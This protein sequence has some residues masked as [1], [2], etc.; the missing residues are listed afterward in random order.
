MSP[1][2]RQPQLGATARA[3]VAS[4]A[5]SRCKPSP[6]T[7]A[8][9]HP[10]SATSCGAISEIDGRASE[11]SSATTPGIARRAAPVAAALIPCGVRS[12]AMRRHMRASSTHASRAARWSSAS[13]RSSPVSCENVGVSSL[14]AP[15]SGEG[16]SFD[17]AQSAVATPC[18]L[19]SG[20]ACAASSRSRTAAASGARSVLKLASAHSAIESSRP[21]KLRSLHKTRTRASTA[22]ND[23][24]SGAQP[25]FPKPCNHCAASTALK[26]LVASVPARRSIACIAASGG[27]PLRSPAAE[28]APAAHAHCAR[29]LASTLSAHSPTRERS[30]L[31]SASAASSPAPALAACHPF[32]RTCSAS[33]ASSPVISDTPSLAASTPAPAVSGE[34]SA[35][36]RALP[37]PALP[38]SCSF[39]LFRCGS[40]A[41]ASL[42][43]FP[44]AR[45]RFV[46][47]AL[48]STAAAA[49]AGARTRTGGGGAFPALASASF[50]RS[51]PSR[52]SFCCC[53]PV[54]APPL[55][56]NSSTA[57]SFFSSARTYGSVIARG[58]ADR[59]QR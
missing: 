57:L 17:A 54:T 36:R 1:S 20:E 29:P 24:G 32:A 47:R 30:D 31:H 43:L 26:E 6:P 37:P 49:A 50:A 51:S 42:S 3:L 58:C 27:P 8:N 21:P 41:A 19:R 16:M 4:A 39:R 14:R 56:F 38:P 10:T 48:G 25:V 12:A 2:C 35:S 45:P 55:A 34:W 23:R 11:T 13:S 5:H 7:T 18:A 9:A 40:R 33:A 46:A 15:S 52:E 53:S 59:A 22:D 44:P 28:S